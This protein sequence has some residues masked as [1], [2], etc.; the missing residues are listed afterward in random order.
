MRNDNEYTE[1][2]SC[3]TEEQAYGFMQAGE[4]TSA[5]FPKERQSL[6]DVKKPHF[7]IPYVAV[8]S[9]MLLFASIIFA[10]VAMYNGFEFWDGLKRYDFYFERMRRWKG[11]YYIPFL[12]YYVVE[13]VVSLLLIVSHC[14][15]F[16]NN[17]GKKL[18]VIEGIILIISAV[19]TSPS[20]LSS[21]GMFI[22][23]SI[24][25]KSGLVLK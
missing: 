4:K 25:V 1:Q 20:I 10:M 23:G 12:T 13:S 3:F 7:A 24:Y 11:S 6:S 18:I 8:F 14:I 17:L 22:I 15:I 5:T 19:L 16:K 2:S 9:L 21:I